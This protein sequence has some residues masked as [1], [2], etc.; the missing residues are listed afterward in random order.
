MSRAVVEVVVFDVEHGG[1]GVSVTV[2]ADCE[3]SF[4]RFVDIVVA[5]F[6][7]VVVQDVVSAAGVADVDGCSSFGELV[8]DD[9]HCRTI[10][11]GDRHPSGVGCSFV[12][13]E[14]VVGN[15]HFLVTLLR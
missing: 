15:S 11:A 3:V 4:S 2:E 14:D 6:G 10:A 9:F 12:F 1:S 8:V 13:R 5:Y 7:E